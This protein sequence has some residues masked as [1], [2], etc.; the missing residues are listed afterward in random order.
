MPLSMYEASVPA[1]VRM[2]TQLDAILDKAEAYATA[3]KI[4]PLVLTGA[5]IAP[6]MFPLSRQVQIA[7]DF[8]KGAVARLSGRDVPSWPDAPDAS[9]AALMM[10]RP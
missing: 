6:D 2:L 7:C 8:S 5:R 10:G 9:F 3:K 4:D 1:F